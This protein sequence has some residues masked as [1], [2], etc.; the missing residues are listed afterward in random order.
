MLF[1]LI[2]LPLRALQ[3]HLFGGTLLHDVQREVVRLQQFPMQWGKSTWYWPMDLLATHYDYML[4]AYERL[5]ARDVSAERPILRS[6]IC[7]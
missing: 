7:L 2:F 3:A 4:K 6:C 5:N 1:T